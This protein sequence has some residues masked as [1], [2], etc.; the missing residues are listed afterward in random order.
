MNL[1]DPKEYTDGLQFFRDTHKLILHNC[2]ELE[3]LLADAQKNGVFAS[4]AANKEWNSVLDFF[5]KSAPQHERDE[6]KYLFPLI[7][8]KVPRV[9][10]QQPGATI[11]FLI[12]GHEVLQIATIKL[13]HDWDAFRKQKRDPAELVASHSAHEKE[14]ADFI[15]GGTELV[16]LYR[17][18]A[19]TEETQ[20][21]TVADKVLNGKDKLQ[22]ADT[23][24]AEYD[25]QATTPVPQFEGQQFSNSGYIVNYVNAEA[26]PED[27]SDGEYAGSD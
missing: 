20:V 22:L 18:H 7:A 24:R 27:A 10:F 25:N 11:R 14:D 21:Y 6:E 2:A 4:F 17:E 16:K 26:K 23:L 8:A 13:V 9:G 19:A 12:E 15:A 1:P 3:R 5:L